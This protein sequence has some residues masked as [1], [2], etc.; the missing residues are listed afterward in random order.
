LWGTAKMSNTNKIQHFQN[1]ALRKIMNVPPHIY[2]I[3]SDLH[4][5]LSMETVTE[6]AVRLHEN[7]HSRVSLIQIIPGNP[8]CR[9]KSN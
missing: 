6:E 5:D 7:V 1:I 4:K 2:I 9:L 3:Q 8:S